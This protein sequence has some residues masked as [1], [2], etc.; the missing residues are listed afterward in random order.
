M[1]QV[2][3]RSRSMSMA[4]VSELRASARVGQTAT[5][6]ASSHWKQTTGVPSS[7]PRRWMLIRVFAG[8]PSEPWAK[9]QASSHLPQ[10]MQRSTETL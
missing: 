7:G 2:M 10:A 9:A 3:Q 5:H 6:A 4:P 8:R 1:R